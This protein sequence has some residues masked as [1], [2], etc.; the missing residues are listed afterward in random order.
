MH[1]P[2]GEKPGRLQYYIGKLVGSLQL[3]PPLFE[4]AYLPQYIKEHND[5]EKERQQHT[6]L[7]LMAIFQKG[8]LTT[9]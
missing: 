7:H 6:V 5:N 4:P 9:N 1:F 8:Q 3:S 2:G